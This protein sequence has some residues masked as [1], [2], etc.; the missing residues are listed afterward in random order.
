LC[1]EFPLIQFASSNIDLSIVKNEQNIRWLHVEDQNSSFNFNVESFQALSRLA[2]FK[3]NFP[4]LNLNI[5][6]P[7]N[8][9][10]TIER[11]QKFPFGEG[12]RSITLNLENQAYLCQVL[13]L[14]LA[15]FPNLKKLDIVEQDETRSVSQSIMHPQ[16]HTG[17]ST[18]ILA[19]PCP[20]NT[21]LY[22]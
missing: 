3:L 12:C 4:H 10:K 16:A 6:G 7:S 11:I 22:R 15:H 19:Y 17:L 13:N 21:E 8:D 2:N 18:L 14:I 9:S 5:S 1:A 20:G